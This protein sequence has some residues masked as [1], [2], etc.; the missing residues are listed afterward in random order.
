MLFAA[1]CTND[2]EQLSNEGKTTTVSFKV[3]TP[4]IASRAIGDGTTATKLNYATYIVNGDDV[5]LLED[6]SLTNFTTIEDKKATL[7]L[8][9]V[10]GLE[11]KVVF[12][13]AAENAPY[14]FDA[15][16]KKVTVN[17]DNAISN[18][19]NRDAFY[20]CE[21]FTVESADTKT[22]K[23]KRPFAQLNIGTSDLELAAKAG[24]K[25]THS[26]V[27]VTGLYSE[28]NLMT[29]EATGN[30]AEQAFEYAA[31][32]TNE[33][34]PAEG[35]NYLA[36]N[37][38]LV[39]EAATNGDKALVDVTFG[40]AEKDAEGNTVNEFSRTVGSVPVQRNY[41]TNI[42]GKLLTSTTDINVEI[43]PEYDGESNNEHLYYKEGD[44]YYI[45][46]AE[47]LNYFA[48]QVN[49][50]N[51]EWLNAHVALDCDIDLNESRST[52]NWTPIGLSK[53]LANGKTF[54]GTFDGKGHT[55]RN[56]V[57]EGTDVAGLFGYL[58]AATIKNVTIESATINSNHFAGGIVAWVLNTKG[59]IQVPMVIENCHVKN[60]VIA[61]TPEEVNGEWDNGDKVGGLVGYACFGDGTYQPNEGAKISGCSVENT[62]VK[63][64]RD[65]GGL[66]GYAQYATI[67]NCS[68]I[69]VNLE[70]DL[71]HDYKAP[72][73][74]TTFGL[75]IGRDAGNNTINGKTYKS[76]EKI[77]EEAQDPGATIEITAGE[78]KLPASIAEGVTIIGQ[79]GTVLN[80]PGDGINARG[81][82]VENVEFKSAISF[83]EGSSAAFEGCKISRINAQEKNSLELSFK[84][85]FI[86]GSVAIQ[87]DLLEGGKVSFEDCEL[88]GWNAFGGTGEL[89]VKNT[90]FTYS[91]D[92]NQL[93]IY[94]LDK[95]EFECCE[96]DPNYSIDIKGI[97][98]T[99]NVDVVFNK[100]KVVASDVRNTVST[101]KFI[102]LLDLTMLNS[103]KT[104]SYII[105]GTRVN[106]Q[107]TMV[108]TADELLA[109]TEIKAGQTIILIGDID[110][111][112][113]EFNGLDTFHPENNTT[114][115]GMGFTVSNWTNESGA[116]DMGFIR[117]WVGPVKNVTIANA[118]LKTSGRSAIVAAKVYGNITNCHVVNSTIEDSY[119]ACGIIAG[120]YNAG[121]IY[122]CS[123]AGSS[124]KSSGGTGGIVGVINESAGTRGVYNCSVSNTTVNNTGAYGDAY[125]GALVCGMINI[126]NSTVEFKNCTLENNTKE[127]E[128]VGDL[129][130]SADKD[131]TVVVE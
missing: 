50:G 80:I 23:L 78:F 48:E 104:A 21:E 11:Y 29:G 117:N 129:Y 14:I 114:F 116:S 44:I 39:G 27:K 33:T 106:C 28:L 73:T 100:C 37:Y 63:A 7:N 123:V 119:W 128:Y 107:T 115:D 83:T 6:E 8:N 105:D 75:T 31:I 130:Y 35:Y 41:R 57:C 113:K 16:G 69:N 36:M 88:S 32:P 66:I 90:K 62:T 111:V 67:E 93:R 24:M 109:I 89:T 65:F 131:I 101:K 121:S 71:T 87:L 91:P 120:L 20:H 1:S 103:Y 12:W 77:A 5:T 127:G 17:Y 82:K 42:Y 108:K 26:Y 58:Y 55:I 19:E 61:S 92:Y 51:T 85:C 98:G 13:A 95:A 18:A 64:Y 56:M 125:S 54:R 15:N 94:N 22:V 102:E 68:A 99:K 97:N 81:L 126:S 84:N 74:P 59:N 86:G 38:L 2:V 122:N 52:A 9:L 43:K 10:T 112:G 25:V 46:S 110:L 60:S 49:A 124:A 96:F 118:K 76:D 40:Y 47:G 53:D 3:S 34:F 70:Q 72:N 30:S 4:D 79:K 45:A